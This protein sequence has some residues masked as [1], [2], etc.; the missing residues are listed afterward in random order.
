[1]CHLL[2]S[3]CDPNTVWD[4]WSAW[5]LLLK[6]LVTLSRLVIG[7]RSGFF[8]LVTTTHLKI[9]KLFMRWGADFGIKIQ[10]AKPTDDMAVSEMTV[11]D[12]LE[13]ASSTM[14]D[15]EALVEKLDD[16]TDLVKNGKTKQLGD[17]VV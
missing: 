11:E 8:L 17:V 2:A 12:V 15:R 7:G 10:A 13:L 16:L 1:M 5:G 4:G 14:R 6:K 9:V 3:E